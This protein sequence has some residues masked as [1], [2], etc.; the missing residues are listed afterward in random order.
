MAP[1]MT[2]SVNRRSN[3]TPE[4]TSIERLGRVGSGDDLVAKTFETAGDVRPHDI[5]ILDAQDGFDPPRNS[6]GEAS[7][8]GDRVR[9]LPRRPS[10]R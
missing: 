4:F 5:V 8:A 7:I 3:A 1:G 10:A 9:R 6:G 2:M